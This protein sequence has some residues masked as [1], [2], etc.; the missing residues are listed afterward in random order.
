MAENI[1]K[2][3]IE[4]FETYQTFITENDLKVA[5]DIINQIISY[6]IF[7]KDNFDFDFFLEIKKC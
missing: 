5:A 6:M 4:N 3:N 2:Q 7:L 1:K